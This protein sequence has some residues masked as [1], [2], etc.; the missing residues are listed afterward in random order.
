MKNNNLQEAMKDLSQPL[1]NKARRLTRNEHDA[2]DLMQDTY[3][4]MLEKQHQWNEQKGSLKGWAGTVMRNIFIDEKRRDKVRDT[5]VNDQMH[6]T[7]T[8]N[9]EDDVM[10]RLTLH[11]IRKVIKTLGVVEGA[12]LEDHCFKGLSYKEIAEKHQI[13]IGTVMTHLCRGRKK[14]AKAMAH[15]EA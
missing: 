4:R 5:Y 8:P 6:N 3:L 14:I 15:V 1:K 12:V 2:E 13:P 7:V 10:R 9:H 11:E